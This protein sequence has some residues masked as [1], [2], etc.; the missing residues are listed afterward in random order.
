M[1]GAQFASHGHCMR[2]QRPAAWRFGRGCSVVVCCMFLR[3][4]LEVS[5][6]PYGAWLFFKDARLPGFHPGL[7]SLAP[8]GSGFVATLWS[9]VCGMS[10]ARAEGKIGFDYA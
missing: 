1:H 2:F 9:V 5:R 10:F 7:F 6:H 4:L 3:K 8:C